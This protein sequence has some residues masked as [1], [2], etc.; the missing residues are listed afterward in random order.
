MK[1]F[2]VTHKEVS[3]IP[4]DRTLIGVG[5]D[6]N[7][8]NVEYYDNAGDNIAE[9]N[10]NYCELTALY[11]I[12]KNVKDEDRVGLEHYR[13]FFCEKNLFASKP[14]SE[15][16]IAEI[17][18]EYDVV[19]PKRNRAVPSI[20]GNY[21]KKHFKSD[22]DVCLD[23][24]RQMPDYK[25]AVDPAMAQ[26]S[27][28]VCN[29]FVMS[30]KLADEYCEWLFSVLFQAEKIMD[31]SDYDD[32]ERRVFGFLS[33]RLFNVWLYKKK[34]KCYYAPI[35]GLHVCPIKNKFKSLF[36]KIKK[37]FKRG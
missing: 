26:K 24:I 37:L 9:K 32:Y 28:T 27:E 2:V 16:R 17:L 15:K 23:I 29:M 25:N 20:Y 13:R 35:Y 18:T 4:P 19:L 12:W 14:L 30:K 5:N 6:R 1:L 8:A 22:M 10:A 21:A 34:L 31:I 7:I 3:D 33:E 11:W 36:R